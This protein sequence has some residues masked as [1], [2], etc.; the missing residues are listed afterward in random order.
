VT[1]SDRIASRRPQLAYSEIQGKTKDEKKRRTKAEKIVAVLQHFLGRTD[2]SG[3]TAIDIGCSTGYTVDTL[4]RAG[5]TVIGLDIDEPGLAYA[6][7]LFGEHASFLCADGSALPFADESIDI[8]VFNHI[9][10]HVVDP[11]AVLSEIRR[12]L[13]PDGVAYF[14]FA[15][16][17]GIIEP[18]YRLPF[19]SWLPRKASDRYVSMTGRADEYYEQFRTRSGLMKMCRGLRLWDYT[20]TVLSDS[21]KFK[22]RDMVPPR[23]ASASPKFWR[24]L[25]PIMPTFIWIGTPGTK[26]PAG[27][28]T[29]Q[30]PSPLNR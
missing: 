23:L 11:D 28:P 29:R 25:A 26:K 15:N 4:R 17:F 12:V 27:G 1:D 16:L 13:R 8:V 20:Y 24:A 14:G 10:E 30:A 7:S 22:A 9:Y 21:E 2:L 5:C 6:D 3:Y 19:L 18:H